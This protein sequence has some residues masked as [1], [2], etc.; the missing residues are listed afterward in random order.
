MS[1]YR[2]PPRIRARYLD[3]PSPLPPLLIHTR[4]NATARTHTY[5]PSSTCALLANAHI[6]DALSLSRPLSSRLS[7]TPPL[8]LSLS[9]SRMHTRVT[10]RVH[11]CSQS[12]NGE[13]Y[14]CD[15]RNNAPNPSAGEREGWEMQHPLSRAAS[16]YLARLAFAMH[17][18]ISRTNFGWHP[19]AI[20]KPI[21][22]SL[23][24][25]LPP[26]S[27]F[28]LS[29]SPARFWQTLDPSLRRELSVEGIDRST[30]I[31]RARDKDAIDDLT[32]YV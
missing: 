29:L 22:V 28:L 20:R 6:Y 19:C 5:V 16:R 25:S 27:P 9:F 30:C 18:L 13:Y 3:P 10:L 32:A 1:G 21:S 31:Q 4:T 8:P 14:Y 23:S 26:P 15:S 12:C 17:A 11:W 7:H 2:L 24:L